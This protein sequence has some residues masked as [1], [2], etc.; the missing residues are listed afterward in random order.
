[1]AEPNVVMGSRMI[2]DI[3]LGDLRVP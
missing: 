2:G 3:T 1:M